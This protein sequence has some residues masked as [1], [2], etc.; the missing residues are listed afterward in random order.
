MAQENVHLAIFK[1]ENLDEAS[2]AIEML[3]GM[4][5][6]DHDMTILSGIPY[7]DKILGR[8]ISW[9]RIVRIAL[10]GAVV[11]FLLAVFLTFGTVLWYPQRVGGQ[12][13]YAVPT[14]FVVIFEITMLGMLV[15]TFIG[16]F[17]ETISPSFGPK[18]YHPRISDGNIG[19]LFTCAPEKAQ[20]V[21]AALSKAGAELIPASEVQQ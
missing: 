20:E 17:V 18:G 14:S 21:D 3:R 9:T 19:I 4:G 1:E 8:P 12:P 6:P 7:S 16:V 2:N 13:I 5:V 10:A 15:S 11:G